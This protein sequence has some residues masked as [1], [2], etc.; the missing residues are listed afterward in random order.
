MKLPRHHFPLID[1]LASSG[2]ISELKEVK[3][4]ALQPDTPNRVA[5]LGFTTPDDHDLFSFTRIV[6]ARLEMIER[7]W[8]EMREEDRFR[9]RV[10]PVEFGGFY[11]P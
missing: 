4:Y 8:E 7:A 9:V 1:E 6:S 5:Y 3:L 11:L 2:I 10:V